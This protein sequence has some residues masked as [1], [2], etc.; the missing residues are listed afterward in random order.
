MYTRVQQYTLSNV[1]IFKSIIQKLYS[2]FHTYI[3]IRRDQFLYFEPDYTQRIQY[4]QFSHQHL[5]STLGKYIVLIVANSVNN[6]RQ[7]LQCH[8][9]TVYPSQIKNAISEEIDLDEFAHKTEAQRLQSQQN[10]KI[11]IQKAKKFQKMIKPDSLYNDAGDRKNVQFNQQIS[12]I[13]YEFDKE[14]RWCYVKDGPGYN[15]ED[16]E[17]VSQF[18]M[19]ILIS[20]DNLTQMSNQTYFALINT[21]I[22]TQI[23]FEYIEIVK[24]NIQFN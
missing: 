14:E 17:L 15:G 23:L 24:V 6:K 10:R 2:H 18:T 21:Q 8:R 7:Q 11:L 13:G 1:V 3:F 9:Q 22:N 12:G 19:L 4:Q 16:M 20:F 5:Y